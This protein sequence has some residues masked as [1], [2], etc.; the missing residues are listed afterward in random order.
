MIGLDRIFIGVTIY[1]GTN[2][3]AEGKSFNNV[4]CIRKSDLGAEVERQSYFS[5]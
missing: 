2:L 5:I 3:K 4:H 1:S